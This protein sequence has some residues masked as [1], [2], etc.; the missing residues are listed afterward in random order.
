MANPA[1]TRSPPTKANPPSAHC[2]KP[3]KHMANYVAADGDFAA[4]FDALKMLFY[5]ATLQTSMLQL[6]TTSLTLIL[7]LELTP[8]RPRRAPTRLQAIFSARTALTPQQES[9]EISRFLAI[10]EQE[11]AQDTKTRVT[12]ACEP[13]NEAGSTEMGRSH[14][15]SNANGA[16]NDIEAAEPKNDND[17]DARN[18]TPPTS[19]PRQ[20]DSPLASYERP[21]KKQR[22]SFD[23]N[24]AIIKNKHYN[25]VVKCDS[26]KIPAFN[27]EDLS[28]DKRGTIRTAFDSA[29][30]CTS[31][32]RNPTITR[33]EIVE[34]AKPIK[35]FD[36]NARFTTVLPED[37]LPENSDDAILSSDERALEQDLTDLN[38]P[39]IGGERDETVTAEM[40]DNHSTKRK[41]MYGADNEYTP[42]T[43]EHV[44]F[45]PGTV[46]RRSLRQTNSS[47]AST[48][49]LRLGTLRATHTASMRSYTAAQCSSL[50]LRPAQPPAALAAF[51][52]PVSRREHPVHGD[53]INGPGHNDGIGPMSERDPG[54]ENAVNPNFNDDICENVLAVVNIRNPNK[55]NGRNIHQDSSPGREIEIPTS[56]SPTCKTPADTTHAS[57]D[58]LTSTF[59]AQPHAMSAFHRP[60]TKIYG[61]TD[62]TNKKTTRFSSVTY[63]NF[64]SKKTAAL[65]TAIPFIF[66]PSLKTLIFFIPSSTDYETSSTACNASRLIQDPEAF[67]IPTPFSFDRHPSPFTFA[68]ETFSPLFSHFTATDGAYDCLS[69]TTGITNFVEAMSSDHPTDPYRLDTPFVPLPTDST[70]DP[71]H[72]VPFLQHSS[73][74]DSRTNPHAALLYYPDATLQDNVNGPVTMRNLPACVDVSITA[75]SFCLRYIQSDAAT[76]KCIRDLTTDHLRHFFRELHPS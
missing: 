71:I 43:P 56:N 73:E 41:F 32:I 45:P 5:L 13:S 54:I 18:N 16:T 27:A 64:S 36:E 30:Q 44:V 1:P 10:V 72:H 9:A 12:Y 46:L 24:V 33:R 25:E 52:S 53:A 57:V 8:S 34:T 7:Q 39:E 29:F 47:S 63:H 11:R 23:T 20:E 55:T 40:D 48:A 21:I 26:F 6:L 38:P 19:L 70:L 50:G 15:I 76:K 62:K 14:S 69:T 66:N 3:T 2:V 68:S 75:A 42:A 17:D 22:V 37:A 74:L 60:D 51:Q 31:P 61:E 35:L 49:L 28:N 65:Q 67:R 4:P 58:M 59:P